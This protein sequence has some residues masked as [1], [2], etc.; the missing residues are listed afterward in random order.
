M[1]NWTNYIIFCIVLMALILK[2]LLLYTHLL[3]DPNA[4]SHTED[5]CNVSFLSTQFA[6]EL[7]CFQAGP[8]LTTIFVVL[9]WFTLYKYFS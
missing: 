2:Y 4:C 1:E 7:K 6:I 9:K 8:L 3:A 5:N